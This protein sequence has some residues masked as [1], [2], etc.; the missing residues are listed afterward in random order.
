MLP[1]DNMPSVI[2]NVGTMTLCWQLPML[3]KQFDRRYY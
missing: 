1:E 3:P 2:L